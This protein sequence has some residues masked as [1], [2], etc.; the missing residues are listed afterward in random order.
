[1]RYNVIATNGRLTMRGDTTH[2]MWTLLKA[3]QDVG[4]DFTR[5][6]WDELVRSTM[7]DSAR[8]SG[9]GTT[10]RSHDVAVLPLTREWQVTAVD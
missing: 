4:R 3:G 7:F 5:P 8:W 10:E 9:H 6:F 1:M 2:A